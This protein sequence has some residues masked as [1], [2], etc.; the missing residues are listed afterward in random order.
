M[1]VTPERVRWELVSRAE[2]LGSIRAAA[3]ACGVALSVAQRWVSRHK[4]SQSVGVAKKTGRPRALSTGAARRGAE[5][6][7]S[8]DFGS[9]AAAAQQ[10]HKEGLTAELVHR[11]TVLRAATR[12]ARLDGDPIRPLRGKPSK[13]LTAKTKQQRLAFAAANKTRDWRSVMF[14]DRKRF[15]FLHPGAK[16]KPLQWVRRGQRR[17]AAAVNRP[18]GLNLYMGITARGVTAVHMVAGTS[19]HHSQHTNKK[20]QAARNITAGEYREVLSK[21]LLPEGQRLLGG[22]GLSAWVLQ[23]DNDPTHRVATTTIQQHNRQRGSSVSLLANWP[24]HSPDLNLIENVW[25]YVQQRVNARGCATFEEFKAAV[26]EELA[27]V[28]QQVLTNLY[29]SMPKRLAIVLQRGGDKC[30][31]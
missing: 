6:L 12:Q 17:E 1:K 15:L 19:K 20:G 26:L 23:Q 18:M 16:V 9:A 7:C 24:P 2:E 25:A 22:Q 30:G 10:L 27:A 4:T 31:C 29:A 8:D 3:K 11:T 21:T 28:P 5:L 14:T 13:E